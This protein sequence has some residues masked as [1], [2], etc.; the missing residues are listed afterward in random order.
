MLEGREKFLEVRPVTETVQI[1]CQR[2]HTEVM[3]MFQDGD[4]MKRRFGVFLGNLDPGVA[5]TWFIYQSKKDKKST[6]NIGA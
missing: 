3:L 4:C 2:H 1:V 5:P 6:A